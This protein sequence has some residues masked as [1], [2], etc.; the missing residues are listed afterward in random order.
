MK[1]TFLFVFFAL[2]NMA[3]AQDDVVPILS[4]PS[5]NHMSNP[6]WL[7]V[8]TATSEDNTLN[9]EMFAENHRPSL[10]IVI[11]HLKKETEKYKSQGRQDDPCMTNFIS[12][13]SVTNLSVQSLAAQSKA[14]ILGTVVGVHQGFYRSYPASLLEIDVEK[15][16]LYFDGG[17]PAKKVFIFYPWANFKIGDVTYCRESDIKLQKPILGS[18]IL[19]TPDSPK[20]SA[21]VEFYYL[22]E[23]QFFMN[24]TIEG[25]LEFSTVEE[26]Y[27]QLSSRVKPLPE[28]SREN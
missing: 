21:E 5:G 20:R 4:D 9:I 2:M 22:P 13:F 23:G 17:A 1:Q 3:F 24:E 16:A 8:E 11:A 18:K 25:L 15:H 6:F 10:Q 27:D 28:I 26:L 14:V 7:S 12:H 19:I